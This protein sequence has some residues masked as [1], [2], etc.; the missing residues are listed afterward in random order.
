MYTLNERII[1]VVISATKARNNFFTLMNEVD[2]PIVITGKKG[3]KVM[4]DEDD[5]RSIEE[6]MY[7]SSI[8]GL[9]D[10]IKQAQKDDDFIDA[11]D[12]EW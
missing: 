4:I 2:E 7:L 9:V 12:L 5:W 3:N 11:K 8:P 1:M 10:S 6:T